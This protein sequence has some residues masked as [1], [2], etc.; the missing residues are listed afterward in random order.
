[1]NDGLLRTLVPQVIGV[2]V[3]RG[4]DFATAEDA[5]Q[6]ALLEAHRT[7][8]E[9]PPDDPKGWLVTVAQRRAVDIVRAESSRRRR[10]ETAA[11]EPPQGPTEHGDD[12]LL[13]LF[14]CCHPSL[15]PASAV[16]LTLRA[17]GGL[18]THE[19]AEAFLVPEATMA[20]RISRA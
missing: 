4:T 19:I 9:R 15:T 5:V 8:S 14:L 6:E 3:R 11:L 16:A 7:W 10:E 13:L 18:T 1:M 17:V 20:Q 2:L 12:T